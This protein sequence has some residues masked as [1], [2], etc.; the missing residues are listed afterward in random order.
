[1]PSVLPVLIERAQP[2]PLPYDNRSC[3]A[4]E[5]RGEHHDAELCLRGNDD[6]RAVV[7]AIAA[8][9]PTVEADCRKAGLRDAV[10][11]E[12]ESSGVVMDWV[13]AADSLIHGHFSHRS[14]EHTSE[15]Q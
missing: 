5:R 12:A 15:L 1:M 7:I 14:E 3:R 10:P 9:D 2:H 8:L 4:A 13:E 11:S 6:R